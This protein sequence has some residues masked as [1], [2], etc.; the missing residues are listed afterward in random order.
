MPHILTVHSAA[1]DDSVIKEAARCIRDGGIIIYPTET[2]YGMGALYSNEQ[3]LTKLFRIKSRDFSKPVLLL[4]PDISSIEAVASEVPPEAHVLARHFWPGPLTLLLKPSP[5]LSS[6]L[7]G[8]D[9]T[10]GMR[11][12]SDPVASHLLAAL[13]DCI[14][15]TSANL[16]GGISPTA[17]HEI[18][19]VLLD[20]VDLVIDAGTTPG[21]RPSTVFDVSCRPFK[22]VREG[23]VGVRDIMRVLHQSPDGAG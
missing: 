5:H 4:I 8:E 19:D 17:V 2:F 11:V 1:P 14:T 20:A 21:G 18:P 12:S 6:L 22:I 9:N 10:V 16:S 3:A 7:I 13:Q 23:A 15:A